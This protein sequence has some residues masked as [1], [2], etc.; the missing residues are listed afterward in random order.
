MNSSDIK[1][2]H[3]NVK[4]VFNINITHNSFRKA[5]GPHSSYEM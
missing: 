5:T 1:N 4:Y 2:H 3:S